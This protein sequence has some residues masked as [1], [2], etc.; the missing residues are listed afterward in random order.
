[1]KLQKHEDAPHTIP[2]DILKELEWLRKENADLR[3]MVNDK[4]QRIDEQSQTIADLRK[5]KETMR[6]TIEMLQQ[7][8]RGTCILSQN[9]I[10]FFQDTDGS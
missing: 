7:N 5:D 6:T 8:A 10:C 4:Q 3:I 2:A 9:D 1:M